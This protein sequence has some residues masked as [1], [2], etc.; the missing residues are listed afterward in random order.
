MSEMIRVKKVE[1]GYQVRCGLCVDATPARV[2]ATVEDAERNGRESGYVLTGGG[3]N[4][5]FWACRDCIGKW[6]RRSR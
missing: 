1:G 5:V 3:S 4:P 6:H 2:G